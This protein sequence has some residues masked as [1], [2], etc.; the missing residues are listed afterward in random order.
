M[1]RRSLHRVTLPRSPRGLSRRPRRVLTYNLKRALKRATMRDCGRRCVYC[2]AFLQLDDATLDHV[3]PLSHGGP[4][5]AGNLVAAC[6]GCN[7]MKG[8]MLP[9]EFF[10]RYPLA[11][12]NFM[13][14]ARAVHRAL[15][16]CARRAVSLAMA[17]TCVAA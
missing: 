8:D 3:F 10:L 16:R 11:G 14:Y 7:R 13:R 6:A 4:H 12:A 1:S 9:T 5:I 17:E 15:K 2:G